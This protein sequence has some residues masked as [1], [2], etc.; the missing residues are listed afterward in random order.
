MNI[1]TSHTYYYLQPVIIAVSIAVLLSVPYRA[2][3]QTISV[4]DTVAGLGTGVRITGLSSRED[5]YA[6]VTNA[7]GN[8][9]S[10]T[11][12][13]TTDGIAEAWIPQG[14]TETAGEY[15][16]NVTRNNG[17]TLEHT[18]TV[19]P[20]TASLD[21]SQIIMDQSILTSPGQVGGQ[22]VLKDQFG[23][24]IADRPLTLLSSNQQDQIT[25]TTEETDA[26]GIL[27]FALTATT[28]GNRTIRVIDLLSGEVLTTNTTVAVG[29]PALY[30]G[31]SVESIQPYGYPPMYAPQYY[32]PPQQ[33][34]APVTHT[35]SYGS[36]ITGNILGR[37]L[38][39]QAASF[40]IVSGFQISAPRTLEVNEDA[41]ISIT[42]VDQ[43]G[44]KVEDYTGMILLT[45]TDPSAVLPL[46][47]QIQFRPQDLG[48][49][50]LTLGLRFSSPNEHIL[51]AKDSTNA[52]V[53]GS[54]S[55]VVTG[56]AQQ[57]TQQLITLTHPLPDSTVNTLDLTVTGEAPPYINI[58]VMGGSQDTYGETD[59]NGFFSIPVRLSDTQNDHTLRVQEVGGRYDSGNIRVRLDTEAPEIATI[60]F[61]P[62][63][64]TEGEEVLAVIK[65]E[66]GLHSLTMTIGEQTVTLGESVT[67]AGSYQA[68][69]SAPEGNDYQLSVLA[70][71][72]AGNEREVRA[73]LTV[74][75]AAL[76]TVQNLRVDPTEGAALLEWDAVTSEPIDQYRVYVGQSPDEYQFTLDTGRPTTAATVAGLTGGQEYFFTVTALQGDRESSE[77]SNSVST[78]IPGLALT[79]TPQ[80]G[81]L[82]LSWEGVG[83]DLTL[84]MYVLEYGIAPD[85]YTETRMLNGELRS[86]ILR[87]LLPEVT[88]YLKLT[89]VSVTGET[90]EDL[91]ATGQG[92]PIS[93]IAGF[94][95]SASEPAPTNIS[96][97]SPQQ[98]PPQNLHQGAPLITM[99]GLRTTILWIIVVASAG[100]ILRKNRNASRAVTMQHANPDTVHRDIRPVM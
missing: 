32:A 18:F 60:E 12:K 99:T 86:T 33:Q 54:T 49:K 46:G 38:Y 79:V 28:T 96:F 6:S 1:T 15:L 67:E 11:M 71:D 84:S 98:A 93:T 68:L 58:I 50:V 100:W 35:P 92:A 41:T 14:E 39:G 70:T 85:S 4:D 2:H 81:S 3:A 42:A 23:N 55:I 75:K 80:D 52:T 16:V 5:I 48:E 37:P 69:F 97:P 74:N 77:K 73:N 62:D 82:N 61:S 78:I 56:R 91:A 9:L 72:S 19:L 30:M 89:P 45:S 36:Q 88:Y 13:S 26:S 64:P 63:I 57:E 65:S 24:P 31:G 87:D 8:E 27:Q 59:E 22:L 53:E 40:D 95:P 66:Q 34:P 94:H 90:L 17:K 83:D 21:H 25:Q 47:G 44:R 76:Q 20:D 51:V 7:H 29:S 43:N 10:L